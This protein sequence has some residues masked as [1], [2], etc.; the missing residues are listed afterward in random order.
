[1][2]VNLQGLCIRVGIMG[3]DLVQELEGF[4]RKFLLDFLSARRL[5]CSLT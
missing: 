3:L 5:T 1:M 2:F 4:H